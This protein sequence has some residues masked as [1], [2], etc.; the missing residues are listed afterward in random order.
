MACQTNGQ[1]INQSNA[2][3]KAALANLPAA[4]PFEVTARGGNHRVWQRT[5]Y[6][7]GPAGQAVPHLHQFTELATGLHY[8]NEQGQWAESKEEILPAQA[9]GAAAVKG[10]HQVYFPYDI[11]QGVIEMV[12]PDGKHLKSRPVGISYYDG[13]K[14][15]MIAFLTNS[16]GQIISNNQVIYTNAFTEFTADLLCTYRKSG[17]ECDLVFRE[18]PPTPEDFGLSSQGSRLELWTEFFDPPEPVKTMRTANQ[19]DRMADTALQFGKMK[20]IRGKAFIIEQPDSNAQHHR[21]K[22]IPVYK[23]WTHIDGRAFLVE[24]VPVAKIAT[25]M[26]T[27][28]TPTDGSGSS[29]PRHSMLRRASPKRSLPPARLTQSGTN[30]IRVAEINLNGKAG[31]VL[32]YVEIIADATDFIFQGDTT[33]YLSGEYNLQGTTT[34]EG[35]TVIKPEFYG[36]L[37]IDED[38]TVVC[39]TGPYR[40]AIFT[41]VNDNAVGEPIGSGSPDFNDVWNFLNVNSTSAV[42][43]DMRFSYCVGAFNQNDGAIDIW[44]CQFVN[45]DCVLW[46]CN[47]GLHNALVSR[48]PDSGIDAAL[49]LFGSS[50]ILENVTADNGSSLIYFDGGCSATVALTNCLVTSQGLAS[51]GIAAMFTNSTAWI[52]SPAVPVYQVTGAGSFYLTNNSPYRNAGTTNIQSSLLAGLKAK[53]T[54]PPILYSGTTFSADTSFNP[55]AQRDTDAPD[56]GYHY[57]PIDYF[58][59]GVTASG[60]LSF[61]AGTAVGWYESDGGYSIAIG[62]DLAIAFYGTA[63]SPCTF[64]RYET[65]QEGGNGN[66][67]AKGVLGGILGQ[68]NYYTVH[69]SHVNARFTHF[70]GTSW[71]PASYRDY[72]GILDVNAIHC[73]FWAGTLG[74]YVTRSY[75][76]NCLMDRV[77]LW[78]GA[79][80]AVGRMF[81]ENCTFHG[82]SVTF[83]HWEGDVPYWYSSIRNCAFDNTD[84]AMDYADSAYTDYD[85]NA[86]LDSASQTSPAGAHD[87]TVG[88]SFNWQTSWLGNYYLPWNSSLINTG[89]CTADLTALYHFTTQTSQ[90]KETNSV[91]DIGYHYVAVD[92]YSGV[93][94]DSDGDGIPDYLED[95]NGNGVLNNGETD[96]QSATDLGLK[97]FITRPKNNSV[98]P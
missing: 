85:Y 39:N 35:G 31:F 5:V 70:A 20:M 23:T 65:V 15:V 25:Q 2:E 84:L 63:T 32:D 61:T 41:S 48:T 69:P 91:V 75:Y 42:V 57:D 6:E 49:W 33:Y 44:N 13:T 90:V 24:E 54:Y 58:F 60:N 79:D 78:Q 27:L 14:S 17:F 64:A 83:A 62:D 88:S 16:V 82:G 11:Y 98:I 43:H 81:F 21:Q 73:E 55:Q 10:Q 22:E 4:T 53:T 37:D 66:W 1:S 76:T 52:P 45:I 93:L 72:A 71:D 28:P 30:T 7:I 67:T 89:S 97:V 9:G 18:Q 46:G 51:G 94:L 92:A 50:C 47:V 36:Q 96:W 56:L 40:P 12:T 19:Q 29:V 34:F 38:G 87:L 3:R 68:G 8:R 86:Y 80:A 77:S 59:G 26:Q 95:A 74:G